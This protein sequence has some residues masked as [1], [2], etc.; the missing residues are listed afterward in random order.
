MPAHALLIAPLAAAAVLLTACGD[1]SGGP[2]PPDQSA[3]FN[4]ADVQFL[5]AAIPAHGE[6]IAMSRLANEQSA[7]AGVR[8]FARQVIDAQSSE[9]DDMTRLLESWGYSIDEPL[10]GDPGVASLVREADVALLKGMAGSAFDAQFLTSMEQHHQ[11][12]LGAA[13]NVETSGESAELRDITDLIV[14]SQSFEL[15][16]IDRLRDVPSRDDQP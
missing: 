12:V 10:Q 3:S 15:E 1:T 14:R 16:Q 2:P 9:F 7:S 5:Q 6:A 8:L 11:R 4:T 13:R